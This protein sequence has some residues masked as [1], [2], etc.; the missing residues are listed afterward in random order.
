M[1]VQLMHVNAVQGPEGLRAPS[2]T[3]RS[4]GIHHHRS[5]AYGCAYVMAHVLL[6]SVPQS[7]SVTWV[8]HTSGTP[9]REK[10]HVAPNSPVT[11]GRHV[12]RLAPHYWTVT[13]A[14]AAAAGSTAGAPSFPYADVTVYR[15]RL[16]TAG[17][18]HL[19]WRAR[20]STV[21]RVSND[22]PSQL[23][24]TSPASLGALLF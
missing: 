19:Q 18:L 22:A 7:S 3:R 20:R 23:L 1:I 9:R 4:V 24:H 14:Q 21:P 17:S 15:A 13:R 8:T 2:A 16:L 10:T 5:C 12:G 11:R 6:T